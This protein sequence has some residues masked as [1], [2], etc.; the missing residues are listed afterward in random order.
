MKLR[1]I[2]KRRPS[3]SWSFDIERPEEVPKN[4]QPR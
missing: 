1:D 2:Q 3:W 4:K